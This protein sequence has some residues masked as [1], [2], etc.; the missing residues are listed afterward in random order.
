MLTLHAFSPGAGAIFTD[1]KRFYLSSFEEPTKLSDISETIVASFIG[2]WGYQK[3]SCP[4]SMSPEEWPQKIA[5]IR[6]AT[7]H[8]RS[9]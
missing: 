5:G 4:I 9:S 7:R 3:V 6:L 1:G 2:K 8:P